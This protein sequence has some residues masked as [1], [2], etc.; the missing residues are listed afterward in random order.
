MIHSMTAFGSARSE[1]LLGSVSV[2][3]K[4]VNSRYLDLAFR[5]P[6]E[7]RHAET[8]LREI[9]S[10]HLKR[11][12]IEVRVSFARS[13]SLQQHAFEEDQ[14][15]LINE[16]YQAARKI[17]P[18]LAAPGMTDLLHWPAPNEYDEDDSPA[19][20][21]NQC[22]QAARSAL[23]ELILARAREGQ[24]LATAMLDAAKE[25]TK[26]IET[27]E[28]RLPGILNEYRKKLAGKLTDT[29]NAACPA[30]FEQISGAELSARIAAESSLFSLRI[31]VAEEL[32]RL[33]SHLKELSVILSTGKSES[34]SAAKSLSLGKRLDFLFQEMNREVNTLGSKSSSLEITQSVIDLKLLIE[35]LREQAQNIE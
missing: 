9:L 6:D 34:K 10:S 1:F 28:Q 8:A 35:Q 11:G 14:L 24:R 32:T 13:G 20:W 23:Q 25:M 21:L 16:R 7:L 12:K 15:M 27:I 22:M 19:M 17:I 33:D 30:G 31:D 29:L 2:E 26:V 3:L 5:I 18:D 4:G